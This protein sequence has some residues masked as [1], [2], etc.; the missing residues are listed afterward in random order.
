MNLIP[1]EIGILQNLILEEIAI[2]STRVGGTQAEAL[3]RQQFSVELV[4]ALRKLSPTNDANLTEAIDTL[5]KAINA[6]VTG[7][8]MDIAL[9]LVYKAIGRDVI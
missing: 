4:V 3:Q 2:L 6:N 7:I 8:A 5:F 1:K 9:D